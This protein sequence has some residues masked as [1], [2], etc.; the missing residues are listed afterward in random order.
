MQ[1]AY[2]SRTQLYALPAT[3][4]SSDEIAVGMSLPAHLRDHGAVS[5]ARLP[6]NI[7]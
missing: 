1:A 6:T 5:V 4:N 7:R 2:G 3:Q